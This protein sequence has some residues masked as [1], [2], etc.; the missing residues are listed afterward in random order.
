MQITDIDEIHA[1]TSIFHSQ[2]NIKRNGNNIGR[3]SNL[4]CIETV[5]I[6]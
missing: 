1:I 3:K 2:A 4:R 5:M 6:E